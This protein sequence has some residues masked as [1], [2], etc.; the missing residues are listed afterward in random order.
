MTET[1]YYKDL[2]L[3]PHTD[4]VVNDLPL[5]SGHERYLTYMPKTSEGH[6]ME[7][8]TATRRTY[9]S[10]H[11][12]VTI[13]QT[14][15]NKDCTVSMNI[16]S[17]HQWFPGVNFTDAEDVQRTIEA[18]AKGN[19]QF[20]VLFESNRRTIFKQSW[21]DLYREL[22]SRGQLEGLDTVLDQIQSLDG[23]HPVRLAEGNRI[24]LSDRQQLTM[25]V[26]A[27]TNR[28]RDAHLYE[29]Q[30]LTPKLSEDGRTV[31]STRDV[32]VIH[33][34]SDDIYL[35]LG[36]SG[37]ANELIVYAEGVPVPGAI[38]NPYDIDP[39]HIETLR[40]RVQESKNSSDRATQIINSVRER[41]LAAY[42]RSLVAWDAVERDSTK[43]SYRNTVRLDDVDFETAV[44]DA[45]KDALYHVSREYR[46][47]MEL[48]RREEAQLDISDLSSDEPQSEL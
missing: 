26:E 27:V 24:V 19:R 16:N 34:G 5:K 42:E 11:D 25:L 45:V 40:E 13:E 15:Q 10:D 32:E 33:R 12:G 41:K 20:D 37:V 39:K 36:L 2:M 28:G 22:P 4:G 21:N 31:N 3:T 23:L 38:K 43:L 30:I 29:V 7:G 18:S 46:T 17:Y 48:K 6:L 8:A 14:F 44:K 9:R 47:D 35:K 1:K